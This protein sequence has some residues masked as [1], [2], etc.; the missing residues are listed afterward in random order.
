MLDEKVKLLKINTDEYKQLI[1]IIST[2]KDE[3]SRIL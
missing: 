1:D 3:I 2:Q